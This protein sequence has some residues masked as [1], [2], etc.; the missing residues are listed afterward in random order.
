MAVLTKAAQYTIVIEP[1]GDGFHAFCPALK[2]CHTCGDTQA[3]A[4]EYVQD[5]IIGYVASL[6]K[7]G[8]PIPGDVGE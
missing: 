5:A 1:D 8:M 7:H 4:L 6:E 2:G 3:E